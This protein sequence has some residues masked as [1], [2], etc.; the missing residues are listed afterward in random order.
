MEWSSVG[1]DQIDIKIGGA[2][3]AGERLLLRSPSDLLPSLHQRSTI[4]P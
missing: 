2:E 4:F 1:L 3:G